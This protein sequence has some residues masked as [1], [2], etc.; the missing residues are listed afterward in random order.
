MYYTYVIF[1]DVKAVSSARSSKTSLN[2]NRPTQHHNPNNNVLYVTETTYK[3]YQSGINTAKHWL[4]HVTA[5]CPKKA[6]MS[7]V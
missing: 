2:F 4:L 5:F 1:S 7:L 6:Y 3:T